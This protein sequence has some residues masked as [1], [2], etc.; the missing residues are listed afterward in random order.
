MADFEE[1]IDQLEVQLE[2]LESRLAATADM[3][4]VFQRELSGMQDGISGAGREAA[5]FSRSLSTDMRGAFGDLILEGAKVSDVLR[6]V[7]KSMISTTVNGAIR[8]VT[9]AISGALTGGLTNLIGGILPFAQGG[10]FAGGH[11]T[12][13]AKGG[14][15]SS[16]TNF[17]M[18]G[19]VGLMGEAG[20]EAIV[21]LARGA[22][23]SLGIRGGGGGT[24]TVNMNIA[25]PDVAGFKR[26]SSQVAAG[27]QR[28][29][30][31]GQRN[32]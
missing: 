21:P 11:V 24:V 30:A 22:D 31:R 4:A 6:D 14:I 32:N 29:I 7:A 20:P 16:P 17:A 1:E 2:G 10:V 18:R 27:I 5:G 26:S 12:P 13:F 23:G 19:G 9:N 25:T 3:S 15:V 8:P 28:A